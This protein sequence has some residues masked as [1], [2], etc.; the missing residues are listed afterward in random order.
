MYKAPRRDET[1]SPYFQVGANI[2]AMYP[3]TSIFV[4]VGQL[5]IVILVLFSYPLQVH[6]CRNSVDKVL[7]SGRVS[8]Y[9][10]VATDDEDDG[11][12]D[13]HSGG[14]LPTWTFAL[15]TMVIVVSGFSTAFFVSDLRLG[16]PQRKTEESWI[17][18]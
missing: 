15:I 7:H 9:K 3:S 10:A 13:E 16:E 4:A 1:L 2:I 5:A 6:P 17:L 8:T 11:H 18:T 12:G 14:D